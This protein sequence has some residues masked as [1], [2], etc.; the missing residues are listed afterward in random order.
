MKKT[1]LYVL[2]VAQVLI[3]ALQIAHGLDMK[4][5]HFEDGS[6]RITYCLP[7]E[8]AGPYWGGCN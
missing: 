1:L 4:V 2:L 6:G 5:E 8:E 7:F 3:G